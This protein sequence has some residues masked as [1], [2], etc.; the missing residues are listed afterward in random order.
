M[1]GFPKNFRKNSETKIILL[2]LLAITQHRSHTFLD[3]NLKDSQLKDA[4]PKIPRIP[5]Q[6]PKYRRKQIFCRDENKSRRHP[7]TR[8]LRKAINETFSS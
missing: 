4:F 3:F 1:H 7:S 8:P 6:S 5:R 2:T